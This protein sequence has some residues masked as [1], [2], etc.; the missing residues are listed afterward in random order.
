[1]YGIVSA[2]LYV[3]DDPEMSCSIV[4][5]FKVISTRS[6]ICNMYS[7]VIGQFPELPDEMPRRIMHQ[8]SI[9]LLF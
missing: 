3:L 4:D 1:M 9:G 5:K 6:H 8:D 2:Q 7:L